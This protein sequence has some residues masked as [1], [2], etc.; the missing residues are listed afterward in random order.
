MHKK[1]G[2]DTIKHSQLLYLQ[3]LLRKPSPH[4]INAHSSTTSEL[5]R[6]VEGM[7]QTGRMALK[8]ALRNHRDWND[9]TKQEVRIRDLLQA[10]EMWKGIMRRSPSRKAR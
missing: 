1:K 4:N 3:E 5:L 10:E 6:T 8:L 2:Q 7:T 9:R